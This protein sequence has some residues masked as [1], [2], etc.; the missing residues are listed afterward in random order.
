MFRFIVVTLLLSA[1]LLAQSSDPLAQIGDGD[2]VELTL[3][4]GT[5]FRGEVVW[6]AEGRI[7][8]DITFDSP[9]ADGAIVL[10]V[11]QI[12]R[13]VRL[14]KLTREQKDKLLKD[15]EDR[16]KAMLAAIAERE[17]T[18]ADAAA[19]TGTGESVTSAADADLLAKFP[20]GDWTPERRKDLMAK[21]AA[22][23]T[24]EEQEF[25]AK[26]TDWKHAFDRQQRDA[27]LD[28]FS[29]AN[30]W[31]DKR[32]AD[33]VGRDPASLSADERE[34]VATHDQLVQ[35][36]AEKAT[37]DRA[38]LLTEF[39]PGA[40]WNDQ[41]YERLKTQFIRISVPPT[42][43][44]QKFLDHYD[45]WQKAMKEREDKLA[46]DEELKKELKKEIDKEKEGETPK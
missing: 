36:R 33:L 27:R 15:K 32:Y 7:K 24:E 30:G 13:A 26:Y 10:D 16:R 5:V 40:E 39:P 37:E 17:K 21:D 35:G 29:P 44:E 6:C 46:A 11:P 19:A 20:P 14:E 42:A 12:G 23:L 25:L 2:R 3:K 41:A 1:P 34:F 8:I 45:D 9:D 28:R 22:K 4:N 18:A 38:D 31:D 43:R